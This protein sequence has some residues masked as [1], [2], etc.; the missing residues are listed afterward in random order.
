VISAVFFWVCSL[1]IVISANSFFS[2][3]HFVVGPKGL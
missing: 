1:R 2:R 3:I